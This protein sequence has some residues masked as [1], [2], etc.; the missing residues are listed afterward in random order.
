[1]NNYF[2]MGNNKKTKQEKKKVNMDYCIMEQQ[3]G[4]NKQQRG[5]KN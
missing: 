2:K 5:H 4:H 3:R 1:M